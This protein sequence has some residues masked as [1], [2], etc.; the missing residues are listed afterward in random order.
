MR[1]IQFQPA[2][3]LAASFA[4]A[5]LLGTAVLSMPF[6]TTAGS[7]SFVD[8]LFTA[9][10]A[11]CVTG[12]IVKDTPVDFTPA[13][14]AVILGLVQI[15]GLG[16]MT[17]STLVL[18][19]SGLRISI[20]DRLLIQS[21]YHP[22]LPRD[23]VSLIRSLFFFTFVTEAVGAGV[24]SLF[25]VPDFGWLA[26]AKLAVFHS[27]SAFC[28]AGFSLFSDSFMAYRGHAGVN[29]ALVS[30]IVLGGIGFPVLREVRERLAG[31]LKGRAVRGSLHL[32]LV[33][34]TTGLLIVVAFAFFY[35]AERNSALETYGGGERALASLFQGVTARTAGFQTLDLRT[36]GPASVLFLLLLMFV[37]A[38]PAS[39]GGGVKTS[40]V[41]VLWLLVRSRI[42]ARESVTGFKRT[43][44]GAATGKALL[45]IA[46]ALAVIFLAALT[47]VAVQP[48]LGLRDALFEAFSAFGTVG[49]SLGVTPGL[50]PLNKLVIILTMYIGRIGPLTF[51]YIFGRGM[52]KGRFEYAEEAVLVG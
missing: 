42:K 22:G 29:L 7:L 31:R 13:G 37:G 45:L 14:Q 28:N 18:V 1:E 39:T 3:V 41:A 32:K 17:F 10:S 6:A 52:A 36:L 49:L 23:F 25:F 34:I 26:G 40:T 35:F 5:I 50:A 2:R 46:L 30:L 48:V 44:P 47:L 11:V 51:L 38:S 43:V 8:A 20:R 19:V 16:I 15:G 4:I 9:T 27:I 33:L 24:L 12:L 21:S